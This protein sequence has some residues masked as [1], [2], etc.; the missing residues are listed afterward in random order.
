MTVKL[1]H[2][3]NCGIQGAKTQ[4]NSQDGFVHLIPENGKREEQIKTRR[5]LDST[6]LYKNKCYLFLSVAECQ[7]RIITYILVEA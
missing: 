3:C 1:Q 6:C 4:D 2:L 5:C 7:G